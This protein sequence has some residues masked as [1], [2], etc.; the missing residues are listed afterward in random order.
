MELI[1]QHQVVILTAETG[2]GK[3]TQIPQFIKGNVVIA[4]PRRLAAMSLAKRVSAEMNDNSVAYAVRF[5]DNMTENTRILFCTD[6]WLLRQS[7]QDPLLKKYSVIIL[8][9]V[10]ERGL[11]SDVLLGFIKQILPKRKDLKLILMSATMDQQLLANY[12]KDFNQ[13]LVSIPT[14][15]HKVEL[16]HMDKSPESYKQAAVDAIIKIH[17]TK[18]DGHIL[19]FLPGMEEIEGLADMVKRKLKI[20]QKE[21]IL[22]GKLLPQLHCMTLYAANF[23]SKIYQK[24]YA[25]S[26]YRKLIITSNIAETSVTIPGV[27]YVVDSGVMKVKRCIHGIEQLRIESCSKQNCEQRMGRAGREQ[28]GE[29]YRLFTYKDM[30][31][32]EDQIDAEL[33]R[34][35]LASTILLLKGLRL[36]I[37]EF[38][39]LE[40]PNKQNE[41]TAVQ[42][43]LLLNAIAKSENAPN[44]EK[45]Q[46]TKIGKEMTVYPIDP[47]LAR[48]IIEAKDL[49]C[50]SHVIDIVSCLSVESIM[51]N[52]YD[53]DVRVKAW[54]QWQKFINPAGD[55]FTYL[56][57]L[58]SYLSAKKKKEYCAE[59]Y[60]NEKSLKQVVLIRQQLR[61]IV[62][63]IDSNVDYNIE[64]ITKCF[65][66]GFKFNMAKLE[67]TMYKS[68]ISKNIVYLHPSSVLFQLK[69]K[70]EL[71]IYHEQLMTTKLYV[72]SL[73]HVDMKLVQ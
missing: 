20:I 40:P 65:I 7:L 29:C 3:S 33:L 48:T 72:R 26:E 52:A 49:N 27:V 31:K 25:V 4:Q 30:L 6:G 51:Q 71:I 16:F 57:I 73:M 67:G 9:E 70:P 19:C 10:H 62:K 18:P 24:L 54:Q 15:Q 44:G 46:I 8:D 17:T 60:L 47:A 13:K 64:D 68:I 38:S 50:A 56:N 66:K 39:W 23:N 21:Y 2:S 12:F 42:Q 69:Q 1:E 28:P 22:K 45:F 37:N 36:N 63:N 5:D 53:E 11:R 35:N 55:H 59:H 41:L 34:T 58:K 14:R 43:L 61:Q 32:M